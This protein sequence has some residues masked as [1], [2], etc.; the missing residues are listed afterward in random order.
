[1]T[2]MAGS[3]GG[4]N[5]SP[6]NSNSSVGGEHGTSSTAPGTASSTG[7]VDVA[8][9]GGAGRVFGTG[10]GAGAGAFGAGGGGAFGGSWRGGKK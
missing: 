6:V 7:F 8:G 4:F 3:M 2:S 9:G 10:V 1:M 5:T